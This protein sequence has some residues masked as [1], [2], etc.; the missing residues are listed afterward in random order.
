[1]ICLHVRCDRCPFVSRSQ[2][3]DSQS[4][5]TY[6][7]IRQAIYISV[8]S[9]HDW[10]ADT[11]H[12]WFASTV[13]VLHDS[14]PLP[15]VDCC[16]FC[17]VFVLIVQNPFLTRLCPRT[18]FNEAVTS[19]PGLARWGLECI[20]GQ[21]NELLFIPSLGHLFSGNSQLVWCIGS[22]LW[23]PQMGPSAPANPFQY[24]LPTICE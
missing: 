1:M 24:C 13:T 2:E 3:T 19:L 14:F 23:C 12:S 6:Q 9:P 10:S 16:V 4:S 11:Y 17:F 15:L 7:F 8:V 20:A 21:F 22:V 18:I 5:H